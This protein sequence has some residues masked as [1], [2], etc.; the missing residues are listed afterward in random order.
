[1]PVNICL[2]VLIIAKRF[3]SMIKDYKPLPLIILNYCVAHLSTS[4]EI[5]PPSSNIIAKMFHGGL[6]ES[7]FWKI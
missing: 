5:D 1:M 3:L 6:V 4:R 7:R 2:K